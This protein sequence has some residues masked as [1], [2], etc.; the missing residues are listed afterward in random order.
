M[1]L[2]IIFIRL[3]LGT[4]VTGLFVVKQVFLAVMALFIIIEQS[5]SARMTASIILVLLILTKMAGIVVVVWL[6]FRAVMALLIIVERSGLR[7]GITLSVIEIR[8]ILIAVRWKSANFITVR[9]I[10]GTFAA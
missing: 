4:C 6:T 8:F 1:A 7:A 10:L 9:F 5:F 2:S 3:L